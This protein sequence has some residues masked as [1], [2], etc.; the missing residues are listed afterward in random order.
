METR[1][2]G[3]SG[4]T[5]GVVGLGC[6]GLLDKAPDYYAKA[7]DLMEGA[8]ANCIDLYSPSPD[9]RTNLG[10]AMRGRREK[11]V[12]QGHLCTVWEDGQYKCTRDLQKVRASF[13][14]QLKRLGTDWLD[15]GMIHY[16]DSLANWKKV[17]EGGILDYALG[18]KKQG[19]I[20]ALG[21][22]SHNP[23]VALKAVEE[24]AIE[25]L[26]FSVNPCY[27]LQP[28]DEDVEQ[29]WNRE[30]Y[31][32]P[33]TN[34]DADRAR[35][36]ETCMERGVGIT[37]MKAFG[38]GDLLHA[39][40]SLAGVALTAHQAIAYALDRPAVACVLAGAR[41]LGELEECLSYGAPGSGGSDYADVL[42][43]FP[44][45][46]WKGHC[47]YCG[48]CAPCTEHIDI[49][50]VIKLLNLA[51]A[52]NAVPETVREHYRALP[53]R[54]DACSQCGVCE[55]RCPFEV[56]IREQMA[57]AREVFS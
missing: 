30:K 1:E 39:E 53:V 37:V 49:A 56:K 7:L 32:Q 41:S 5:V 8:G 25:V 42:A 27:D 43:R 6:E 29:L 48:H 46:S 38:G 35:L 45:I 12:L 20:R 51:E 44:R 34:M 47:M 16:V 22:S 18:L 13:E 3:N 17:E 14:D 50:M 23:K 24:G 40:R 55:M 26:M 15:I 9:L 4:L 2:L 54:A 28:A 57:R 19:V 21:L 52:Q 31:K 36:Y 11:F 10:R 33:L